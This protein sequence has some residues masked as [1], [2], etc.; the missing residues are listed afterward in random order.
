MIAIS[1]IFGIGMLYLTPIHRVLHCPDITYHSMP[2]KDTGVVAGDVLPRN[3]LDTF[4]SD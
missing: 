3:Q 1:L 2:V 4:L